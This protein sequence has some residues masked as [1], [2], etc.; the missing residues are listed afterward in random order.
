MDVYRDKTDLLSVY[1]AV[2]TNVIYEGIK[3]ISILWHVGHTGKCLKF[4]KY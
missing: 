2:G 1:L 4:L 3:P